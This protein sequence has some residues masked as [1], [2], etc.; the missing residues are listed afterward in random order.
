MQ[1]WMAS[2]GHHANIMNGNFQEIGIGTATGEY[3]GMANYTM[4]TVDL[5]VPAR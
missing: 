1:M 2:P 3:N 4:Y 5:A